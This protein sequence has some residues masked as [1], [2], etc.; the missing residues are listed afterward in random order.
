[1]AGTQRR[2]QV[3]AP[4]FEPRAGAMAAALPFCGELVATDR[5]APVLTALGRLTG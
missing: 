5:P 1:V 2:L 3:A 4:G